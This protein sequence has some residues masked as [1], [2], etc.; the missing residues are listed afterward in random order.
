MTSRCSVAFCITPSLVSIRLPF[1]GI[2][3]TTRRKAKSRSGSYWRNRPAGKSCLAMN[4]WTTHICCWIKRNLH[5]QLLLLGWLQI[6][7]KLVDHPHHA[8]IGG[9]SVMHGTKAD[10]HISCNVSNCHSTVLHD[11]IAQWVHGIWFAAR[12]RPSG[13][14]LNF[15]WIWAV[16]EAILR[17]PFLFGKHCVITINL[18]NLLDHL[19]LE[20]IKDF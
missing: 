12:F 18:L 2:H 13:A 3:N 11:C 19:C 6:G 5:S 10:V 9:Q 14:L 8:K 17:F 7:H 16:L 4:W 20:I 1:R 15:D